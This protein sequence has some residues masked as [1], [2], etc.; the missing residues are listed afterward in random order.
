LIDIFDYFES[1]RRSIQR[2][3]AIGFLEEPVLVQAFDEHRGL[4]RAQVFFWDGSHLTID[5]IIDTEPG[6]PE[7][8]RYAYTYVQDEQ[9]VFRYD[10]AP[11]YPDLTTFPS[12]KH[13]GPDEHPEPAAQPALKQVFE[14]VERILTAR[15]ED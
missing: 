7:I 10:N 2:H 1:L 12:H 3:R 9:H 4:F 11:H 15:R 6:Y 8:L 13:V 5:E 14:E